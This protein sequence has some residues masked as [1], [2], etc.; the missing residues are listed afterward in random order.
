MRAFKLTNRITSRESQA[1]DAYLHEIGKVDLLK[2]EEEAELARRIRNGDEQALEKL[3]KANL[4]FV[5]SV[6]KQ[7]QNN[8]VSLSDLVNEGNV[9]LLKAA[10]RFDE[11]KGF[12]FISYAIWWIRQTILQAIVEQ[13][14]IVRIPVNKVSKY[15]QVNSAFQD[16]VQKFEREPS[17]AELADLL[18]MKESEV[19]SLLSANTRHV[20]VD[21]PISDDAESSNLLDVLVDEDNIMPDDNLLRESVSIEIL[22]EVHHL[23]PR[24]KEIILA[25][26][27]LDG[28]E[29]TSIEDIADSLD[30]S[31]E[32]VRQIRDRALRK[33]RKAYNRKVLKDYMSE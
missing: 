6:A 2:P 30:L 4:R 27:G 21:A 25:S 11:T 24:E 29:E 9:G 17:A 28:R 19:N 26:F 31:Q 18:D 1:F 32:R 33:L 15:N 12:K 5:V 13:S 20:S 3:T 16:F 22:E 8:G 23:T 10:R 14:R 7:Y